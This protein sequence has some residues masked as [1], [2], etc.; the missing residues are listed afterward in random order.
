[1][2]ERNVEI[3]RT[4]A[5]AWARGDI[6]EIERWIAPDAELRPLR[7]QLE[8]ITYRG[9]EGLR[10]LWDDLNTDWDQLEL[11]VEQMR[12]GGEVVL[13]LGRLTARG[14]A[15]GVEL[16]VPIGQ[17]WELRDGKVVRMEAYSEPADAVRAAGFDPD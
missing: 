17:V 15:S 3:V 5:A 12:D 13:A 16:D 9:H 10:R 2:S 14:R 4:V 7:A 6:D 8:G 1:M 11:P